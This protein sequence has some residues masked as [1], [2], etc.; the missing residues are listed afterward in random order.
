MTEKEPI[1]IEFKYP[2]TMTYLEDA[3][4]WIDTV[5]NSLQPSDPLFEKE[6]FVSGRHEVEKLLL[7]DN[8]T[9]GTYA[10][11]GVKYNSKSRKSVCHTVEVILTSEELA[12]RLEKDHH[13]ATK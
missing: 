11:V 5:K 12:N 7:V 2:W 4:K 13:V 1:R 6:I 3:G 9:D 10:I 8:D